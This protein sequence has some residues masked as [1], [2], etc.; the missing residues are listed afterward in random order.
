VIDLSTWRK[1]WALLDPRERR[2]AWLVLVVIL[3][4]ALS[5]AAMVGSVMPF[6]SVLADSEKVRSLSILAW[7]YEAGGFTSDYSFLVALGFFSLGIIV[8][9]SLLLVIR[10]WAVARF[11]LMRIHTLSYR[12]LATYLK[13]PYEFFLDHHSGEMSTKILS[14]SQE[15][16]VQFIRPAGETIAAVVTII[17]IVAVL[18]W[19]NITVTVVAF[20]L[21][22]GLYGGTFLVSRRLAS[23][24]GKD[25]LEGNR[26]RYRLANEALGGVKDI[27][28]ICGEQAYIDRFLAPSLKVA[29]ANIA[30]QVISQVPIYVMQAVGFG[31]IILLCLVILEPRDL[32]SGAAV[33]SILPLIGVFAFGGQRLLP[34]MSRLYNSLTQLNAGAAALDAIHADLTSLAG[35]RDLAEKPPPPLGLKSTLSLE[36]VS[37]S[38]PAA[39]YAGV[40]DVS[41]TI[42]AGE[43]I[44][45]VGTTGAGKTTLADVFLGLL[46]PTGGRLVADGTEITQDNLPAWLQ[47]VGYVPQ[48]IFL[49]D[50]SVAEN[51]ALG[52]APEEIDRE[53]LSRAAAIAQIDL[54]LAEE[55]PQGYDTVVGERGVR[56]SGGQRQRIGI[57]RALY[58]EADLIVFDEATSA[59]DNMTER[60]VMA[61]IEMLPGDKTI[62]MIAHRLS[63]LEKCDRL[64]VMERG[65]VVGLGT[66]A[67]LLARNVHF[68]NLQSIAATEVEVK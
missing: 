47:T 21:L 22:G 8:A 6:L 12:L 33:G 43:K 59:L 5:S 20:A 39:D 15:V 48:E 55:M 54:F 11:S 19:V 56:L 46:P 66:R 23:R 14:E 45:I 62:I 4:S 9:S 67:E 58:H 16:V 41:F 49:I 51:I 32:A 30:V 64:I 34:E 18:L 38:Y 28:L 35:A 17:A 25:R 65:R 40:R 1:A 52:L 42:L 68:Q 3:V 37:Y 13:Q 29:R 61:A 24:Y 7:A 44:G 2:N 57:A 27:K 63:T 50:A 60:D 53:R 26:A 10:T 31:G 36:Q